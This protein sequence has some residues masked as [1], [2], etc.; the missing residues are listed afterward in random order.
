MDLNILLNVALLSYYLE[1]PF[2]KMYLDKLHN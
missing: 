1:Q 2:F